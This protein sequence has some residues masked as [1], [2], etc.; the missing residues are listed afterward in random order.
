MVVIWIELG[1]ILNCFVMFLI[2]LRICR[3]FRNE[4]FFDLFRMK[5][6]LILYFLFEI[7]KIRI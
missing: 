6:K 7:K 5:V 2:K 3:K 1:F 4:M